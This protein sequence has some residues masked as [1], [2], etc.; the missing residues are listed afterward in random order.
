MADGVI[1]GMF[2]DR[3]IVDEIPDIVEHW[4]TVDYGTS[5][6]TVFLHCGRTLDNKF[7]ILDEYYHS[8]SDGHTK[9]PSQYTT[10]F[11]DFVNRIKTNQG[12][13]VKYDKI[14]IDPSAEAF[15]AQLYVDGVRGVQG[16]DNS[17]KTG[18][19]LVS[20]LIGNDAF[21]IL[22]RC[23]HTIQEIT[24]YVW[25][26]KAQLRGIDQPLKKNDHCMDALRYN[27]ATTKHIWLRK[28]A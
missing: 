7:Y 9:S 24:S 2:E 28:A 14:F 22:R 13:T 3:M 19:E 11:K 25:D 27:V 1:Y 18:I 16:A 12:G 5:N 17:V 21:R 10:E 8:G 4:I 15:I 23:K 20:N 26:E 6:A